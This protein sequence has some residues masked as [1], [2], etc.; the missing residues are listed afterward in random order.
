MNAQHG[1]CRHFNGVQNKTCEAGI[2]YKSIQVDQPLPCIKKYAI[3]AT[4]EKYEEPTEEE[5]RERSEQIKRAINRVKATI[6]LMRKIKDEHK[7]NDWN[8]IE[9]CPVCGGKLHLSHAAYNG[10][11]HGACETDGCVRWIE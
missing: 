1:K 5:V 2:C 8:G 11:T 9:V 6:P 3:G 10:H 4:C 7:G